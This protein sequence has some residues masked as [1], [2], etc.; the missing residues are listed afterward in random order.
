VRQEVGAIHYLNEE[1][2]FLFLMQIFVLLAT[3]KVLGGLFRRWGWP[4]LAGQILTGIL[5]GPTILGRALPGIEAALFPPDLVQRTMIETVSWF[6]V[7]FLLLATGFE[8]S[9]STVWKQG[10][11][12][13]LIGIVGVIVPFAIGCGVFVWLPQGYWGAGAD[14]LTFTLFLATAASISA[15]AVMAKLLH[16]LEILK[17]DLGLSILSGFAVNDIFG[18]LLFTIVLSLARP[19]GTDLEHTVRVLFEF[20][21]FA[22]LCLTLGSRVVGA[23]VGRLKRTTLPQ[24]A[25]TLTVITCLAVLSG[26]L[27]QWIGIHAILGFFLAGIMAGNAPEVSERMREIMSQMVHAVFVPIFFATIG[28]K[29]DFVANTDLLIV[30]AFTA[31]AVGGKFIGAWIAAAMAKF[32]RADALSTGFAFIPGGAMEI[33]VAMLALDLGIIPERVFVAIVFAA[34]S[35]SIAVG[36]LLAWSIR[37]RRAVDSRQFLAKDAVI[38][39]LKGKSR[40]EIIPELCQRLAESMGYAD[41]Q[42][43]ISVVLDREQIMGTGLEK[44]VAVP[45][46]RLEDIER[47]FV[48]FGRSTTGIDWDARDGLATHFVFL[49]LTPEQEEGIQVQILAAI[50]RT[51]IRPDIQSALMSAE[52]ADEAFRILASALTQ[53][54]LSR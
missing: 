25:T 30:V 23:I 50:A 32:P 49:I 2:I 9:V 51:M 4:A 8:V 37:R 41:V 44:G 48:G 24:P 20:L 42:H 43:L 39:D 22:T 26:A 54:A 38:L 36:P 31:V 7:L 40:W 27:T 28:I 35:S 46:G 47:P 12:S 33:V 16:D 19:A 29:I 15:L 21:L 11:A 13:L 17:S 3:A 14:H 53:S 34:L 52:D 5:L 10:K 6:G 1:H 45:H 18:W